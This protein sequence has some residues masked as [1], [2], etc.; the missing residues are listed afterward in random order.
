[1]RHNNLVILAGVMVALVLAGCAS[2]PERELSQKPAYYAVLPNGH[3]PLNPDR[4]SPLYD[5]TTSGIE[6]GFSRYLE[7]KHGRALNLLSL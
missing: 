3:D 1:M 4:L 2:S 7:R 6:E 5:P